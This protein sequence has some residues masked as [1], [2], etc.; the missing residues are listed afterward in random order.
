M[1]AQALLSQVEAAITALLTGGHT[2]YSIGAR[3]VTRLDLKS[4]MDERRMLQA[5]VQRATGGG[6]RIGRITRPGR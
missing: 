6:I 4:L 2:S 1:D 5:E 3:T